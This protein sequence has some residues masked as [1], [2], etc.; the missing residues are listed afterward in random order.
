ML[1]QINWSYFSNFFYEKYF[2]HFYFNYHIN[3][4]NF[5]NLCSRLFNSIWH[6]VPNFNMEK[7]DFKEMVIIVRNIFEAIKFFKTFGE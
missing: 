4:N 6:L 3:N 1:I 2:Y 7:F 5:Q